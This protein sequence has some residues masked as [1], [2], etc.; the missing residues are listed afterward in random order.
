M[1][2]KRKTKLRQYSVDYLAYGFV[3][4]PDN[5]NAPICLICMKTLSNESMRPSKLKNH[6]QT[7]HSHIKD[8]SLDYFKNLKKNYFSRKTVSTMFEMHSLNLDKGLLAS[9]EISNLIARAG[10][11]HNIGE[12]LILPA[13]NIVISKVM[14][15]NSFE[16]IKSIPL[17]NSS[18]SRRIDEMSNDVEN[19]LISLLQTREFALQI[20]ETILC[21]NVAILMAYVRYW[22]NDELAEEM[23]FTRKLNVD[24]KGDTIFQELKEYFDQHK[25]PLR[26]I[27]SCATDGASSMIGRYR[28]FISH[29][30]KLVPNVLC[31]HCVIHRQHLVAKNLGGRLY[32]SL[33]TVI[34]AVNYIKSHPLQDRLFRQLCV[35]NEED[36]NHLILHTAVRWLSKG[37]CLRRFVE[38]WDSISTFFMNNE[39]GKKINVAKCDI[40]Y[41]TDIFQKLNA[42]NKELQGNHCNLI[43]CKE[44]VCSFITKLKLF[45][46]NIS[47]RNFTHFPYLDLVHSELNDNDICVYC[48]HI[49]QLQGDMKIRFDD[50]IAMQIPDWIIN[51]FD[52]NINNVDSELQE[53]LIELQNDHS[54]QIRFKRGFEIMWLNNH[55]INKYTE[56][57]E[58]AKL[59]LVAFPTS[60]LVESG[61]SRMLQLQIKERNRLEITK[62]GDLRLALTKLKPDIEKIVS[63]HQAQG[64]H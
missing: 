58:R 56:L 38:L 12:S 60:Y 21:D 45:K 15:S 30:K 39:L 28:G 63:H 55:T 13:V 5:E 20:D 6:L 8:K 4:A 17:S 3:P 31:I 7:K 26:N 40:F 54:A 37:N 19:Q 35:E 57:W 24:T 25:L 52:T 61:F 46:N 42:L 18:V 62:R 1:N 34:K 33:D 27:L 49:A 47:R 51:P 11:A 23:L 14:N 44:A 22:N 10:K 43:R 53:S 64:S 32:D 16:T 59:F 9:Y 41:L 36:Y 48:E 29:L 2:S 50:I